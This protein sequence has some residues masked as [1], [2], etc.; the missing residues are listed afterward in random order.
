MQLLHITT[1]PMKY[2]LEVEHARLEYQQNF[3]PRANVRTTPQEMK[4]D[5]QRA[6]LRLDTYEARKSLGYAQVGDRIR[7]AAERGKNQISQFTR[8]SVET[9]EELAKIE[10]GVT[11][12]QLVRQRML[13][14]PQSYTMF[15]PSSGPE[16]SYQPGF[17]TTEWQPGDLN[18]DWQI[19]KPPVTYIPGSVR[20]KILE[21]AKVEI[22]YVG[23]PIYCPPSSAPDY[24]EPMA[25]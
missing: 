22:E 15:L 5:S 1:T 21:Y 8:N 6:S 23:K 7:Q 12:A 13:E 10:E 25:G 11:I 3:I 19:Q 9:G 18:Y 16:I 17:L 2:E 14:Q 20:M 4:L 24:E